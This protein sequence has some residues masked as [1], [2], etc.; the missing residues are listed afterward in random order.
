MAATG[1][2]NPLA[3]LADREQARIR[4]AVTTPPPVFCDPTFPEQSAFI[5]DPAR[6]KVVLATR[7]AGKSIA[8]ARY[9]FKVAWEV[10]RCNCLYVGLTR[11]SAKKA[12]WKDG[13]KL[14][15]EQ[16]NLGATPNETDL[17]MTLP[18]GSVIYVLGF[19]ASEK[20][21]GKALGG[22]YALA[23]IDEAQEFT[24]DMVELVFAVLKPAVA[25]YE[26]TI[27]LTGTPGSI[28]PPAGGQDIAIGDPERAQWLYYDLT[29]QQDPQSPGTWA[30]GNPNAGGWR[31]FRWNTFRNPSMKDKI[32][33]EIA[34]LR[35][36]NPRVDE[37]PWFIRNYLG[38]WVIDSSK[39]AYHF[40]SGRN[41]YTGPLPTHEGRRGKWHYVLGIDL[42]FNDPCAFVVLA[43]HDSDPTLHIVHA[44][45]HGRMLLN[46]M[47]NKIKG[48]HFKCFRPIADTDGITCKTCQGEM[49]LAERWEFD[50]IV[51]DPAW[52]QTV[53]DLRA[54]LSV[55][56]TIAQ[57]ADKGGHIELMNRDLIL[58]NIKVNSE[59]CADLI[60]EYAGITWDD[61]ATGRR[62]TH[63]ACVDHCADAALY[64][65]FYC[66]QFISATPV[67]RIPSGT[68][69]WYAQQEQQL[70][71]AAESRVLASRDQ[72][73]RNDRFGW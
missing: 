37:T 4:A 45:K 41:D 39:F 29:H 60:H 14:V 65:F 25:D 59:A 30:I 16:L 27:C 63:P 1:K 7:R 44:E 13:L 43:Y 15:N 6:L 53:E 21:R 42:G 18:N 20:E 71:E 73:N 58:G 68:P 19:D 12:I 8:D 26:G 67:A 38:R 9:L 72:R 49:G 33:R 11:N 48:R 69:E 23:I 2:A 56:I 3:A 55:P 40:L 46:D 32:A 64:G 22:K 28:R 51:I 17:T 61:R 66:Y 31:G 62:E 54:R 24:I 5:R 50:T 10:P 35:A 52:K 36:N 57:K 47:E 70:R 34:D